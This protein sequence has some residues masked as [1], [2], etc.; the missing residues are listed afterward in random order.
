[1]PRAG[2]GRGDEANSSTV[3]PQ[4]LASPPTVGTA[5][6]RARLPVAELGSHMKTRH[7]GIAARSLD[8]SSNSTP[9][10]ISSI[11]HCPTGTLRFVLTTKPRAPFASPVEVAGRMI[12]TSPCAGPRRARGDESFRHTEV[13]PAGKRNSPDNSP[14]FAQQPPAGSRLSTSLRGCSPRRCRGTRCGS[15]RA[16]P[17]PIPAKIPDRR[18]SQAPMG[19]AVSDAPR[20]LTC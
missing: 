14:T 7:G 12:P 3:G 8:S 6:T 20:S 5:A 17:M 18:T 9:A 4:R 10:A 16:A 19:F 2:R 13:M 1:M 15:S 11:R